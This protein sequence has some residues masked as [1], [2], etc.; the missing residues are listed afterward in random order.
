M[1]VFSI[2]ELLVNIHRNAAIEFHLVSLSLWERNHFTVA[3][4]E[5]KRK[6]RIIKIQL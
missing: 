4:P 6:L 5:G 2:L 1:L 3:H